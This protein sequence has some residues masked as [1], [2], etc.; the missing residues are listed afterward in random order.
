MS[1]PVLAEYERLLEAAF[2]QPRGPDGDS[3]SVVGNLETVPSE[4][5][6][7]LPDGA[8]RAVRDVVLHVGGSLYLYEA[9]AF[10][11]RLLGWE[12]PP[13]VPPGGRAIPRDE[14]L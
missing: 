5:W 3:H 8:N 7:W 1:R 6:D 12:E 2:R 9:S 14:L 11:P 10:A 13:A 4:A